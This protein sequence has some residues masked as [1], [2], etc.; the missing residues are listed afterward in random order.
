MSRLSSL[1]RSRRREVWQ[2]FCA[3]LG[4]TYV[5][6]RSAQGD[7]IHLRQG[8]WPVVIDTLQRPKQP[9]YTRVRAP[10]VNRDSFAFR[11]Y[12]RR[13]GSG[14]RKLAGMQDVVVGYPA[15]DDAF[16]IQGND[17]RKL[18]Q[19]FA[20][21][22]LRQLIQWQPE[23]WLA[24]DADQSWMLDTWREGI[25]ELRFQVPKV[26][27]DPQ[28]LRDLYDLFGLLLNHLCDIGSAYDDAPL[29]RPL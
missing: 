18:K 5:K 2:A 12:R 11:I 14:L 21:P 19:L 24:N 13:A 29:R 27:T 9:T 8:P 1:F 26:I 16:I 6:G 10:Y 4:G 3:E 17:T 23:I 15:F 28:R 22:D 25:S 20:H 7:A